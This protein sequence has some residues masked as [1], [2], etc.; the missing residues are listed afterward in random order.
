MREDSDASDN[1]SPSLGD[2]VMPRRPSGV[3]Y[4]EGD[5]YDARA[6]LEENGLSEDRDELIRLLDSG[7]GILQ[8]AAARTLGAQG[9]RTAI[10]QLRRLAADLDVEETARVQAAYALAR[11]DVDG[12]RQLILELLRLPAEAS[13]GPL[14]AAA[15]LA[16]LG[17]PIGF[18]VVRRS[19]ESA[20]PVTAM[21]ACKQI[22]AFA[23]L[24]GR[25][26]ASG[27]KVDLYDAFRRALS[28][29]ERNIVGEAR[30]Q[31]VAL[32]TE[33]ARTIL[34]ADPGGL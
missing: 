23:P 20:N 12:A 13:P 4:D 18:E 9:E 17:D 11:M 33:Q 19:L 26:L 16:R 31:L 27:G 32:D 3:P 24:D 25:P 15:A 5:D 29:P 2:L 14:Q 22:F 28:R 8:A 30:A 34:A 10:E 7:I 6:L 21:I 1:S